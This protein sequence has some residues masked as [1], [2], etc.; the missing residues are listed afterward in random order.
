MLFRLTS[1]EDLLGEVGTTVNEAYNMVEFSPTLLLIVTWDRIPR[2]V[3]PITFRIVCRPNLG[4]NYNGVSGVES[5]GVR[6][7]SVCLGA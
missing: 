2:V 3:D 5:P 1:D 7:S 6:D 4:K